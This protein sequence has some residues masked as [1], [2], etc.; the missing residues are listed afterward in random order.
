M[1]PTGVISNDTILLAIFKGRA[2]LH[3]VN[4]FSSVEP[5]EAPQKNMNFMLVY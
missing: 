5:A 3:Q 2:V 1:N 4:K